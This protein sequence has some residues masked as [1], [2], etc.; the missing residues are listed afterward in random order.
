[1]VWEFLKE[2]K[3]RRLVVFWNIFNMWDLL[4]NFYRRCKVATASYLY[5]ILGPYL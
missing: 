3:C 5:N 4:G 2:V 1:M